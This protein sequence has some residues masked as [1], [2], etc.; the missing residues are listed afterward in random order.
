MTELAPQIDLLT[1]AWKRRYFLVQL[2]RAVAEAQRFRQPLALIHLDVDDLQEHNDV[3]GQASVDGAL[4]WLAARM[5]N[6]LDGRGPIGRLEGGAFATFLPFALEPAL[7]MAERLRRTVPQTRHA[8]AFGDYH[9]TISA[10]VAA[11]RRGEPWGNLFEAAENACRKA[12]QG[13]RDGVV[14]R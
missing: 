14:H 3:H 12:K 4:S 8:S 2:A 7:K 11:L 1:A 5:A 9:L 6:V 10:G 13:G